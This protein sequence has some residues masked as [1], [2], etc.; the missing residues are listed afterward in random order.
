MPEYLVDLPTGKFSHMEIVLAS[1]PK[2]EGS[3]PTFRKAVIDLSVPHKIAPYDKLGC[4]SLISSA[5]HAFFG[6]KSA[7]MN[8][9]RCETF[10]DDP[11]KFNL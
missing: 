1:Q 4:R 5:K 3:S 9:E 11:T 6:S 10:F 2:H 8:Q 7:R